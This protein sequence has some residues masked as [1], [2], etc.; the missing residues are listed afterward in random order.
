M[1]DRRGVVMMLFDLPVQT[2]ELRKIYTDFRK[3]IIRRGYRQF[4]RSVYIKLLRNISSAEGE[5]SWLEKN[6]PEKGDVRVMDMSL[7]QF[8]SLTAIRGAPFEMAVFADDV[9]FL[10][11]ENE[12]VESDEEAFLLFEKDEKDESDEKDEENG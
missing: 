4:Q 12:D 5:R 10:G 2:A 3:Q 1:S 9:V 7:N 6:A 8:R 11:N